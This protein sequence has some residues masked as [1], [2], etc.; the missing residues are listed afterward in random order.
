MISSGFLSKLKKE[1]R[2]ELVEPSENLGRAYLIK[3]ENCLKAAKIVFAG[4][5]YEN[6]VGDAYYAMYNS[7]ISL[8]FRCGIKCENHAATIM[9]LRK[10]F[11][12]PNLGRVL[13]KAKKERIDKQYYVASEKT[14]EFTKDTALEMISD[15]ESF[16]IEIRVFSNKL[17]NKA[18][19]E[20][21]LKFGDLK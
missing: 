1:G 5:L 3:S 21:R 8:L 4:E 19:G 9:L 17:G 6:A 16:I 14:F 13:E 11:G 15:A 10:L 12:I 7:A 20:I 18:I 2:L